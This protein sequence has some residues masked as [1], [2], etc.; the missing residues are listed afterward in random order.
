MAKSHIIALGIAAAVMTNGGAADAA[1]PVSGRWTYENAS[2]P[3][4]A[5]DCSGRIMDFLGV[6]RHD[7]G[8]GVSNYH[9]V[10]VS[11]SSPSFFYV[12]DEFFNVLVRGRVEYTL[13]I[14]DQHHIEIHVPRGGARFALRRCA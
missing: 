7:T 5:K 11:Q 6:R 4:P 13:R 12:V 2:A 14:L 9:N 8:G 3:G 10:S 1:Y